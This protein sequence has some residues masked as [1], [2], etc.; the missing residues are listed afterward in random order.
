M[1][2]HFLGRSAIQDRNA[3]RRLHVKS[4]DIDKKKESTKMGLNLN[5]GSMSVLQS[6]NVNV[7]RGQLLFFFL[8]TERQEFCYGDNIRTVVLKQPCIGEC[9]MEEI[10]LLLQTVLLLLF[11]LNC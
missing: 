6:N 11:L 7:I 9:F 5:K 8:Q 2:N 4:E 1:S 10:S 3:T